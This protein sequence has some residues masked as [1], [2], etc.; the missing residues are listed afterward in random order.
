MTIYKN[1]IL[2][3]V[4]N[5]SAAYILFMGFLQTFN[6]QFAYTLSYIISIVISYFL[7]SKYVFKVPMSLKKFLQFP[8]VYLIQYCFGLIILYYL[9]EYTTIPNFISI[10]IVIILS[11]PL[12]F[13]L[14]KKVLVTKK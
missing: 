11:I 12:T 8:L 7:N 6:Y 5:T 2:V 1:F 10:L 3:G 9:N 4:V 14:S 13:I